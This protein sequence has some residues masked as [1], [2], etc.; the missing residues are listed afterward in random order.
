MFWAHLA[1]TNTAMR[2]RTANVP[3]FDQRVARERIE[4]FKE[5]LSRRR[6]AVPREGPV[7]AQPPRTSAL[8]APLYEW[9]APGRRPPRIVP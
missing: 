7:I 5:L 2:L 4:R 3:D 8:A 6:G 1:D 9:A